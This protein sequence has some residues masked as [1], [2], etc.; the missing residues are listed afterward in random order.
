MTLQI[1]LY[2]LM[3][4]T[5]SERVNF[6]IT[7]Q[8]PDRAEIICFQGKVATSAFMDMNGEELTEDDLNELVEGTRNIFIKGQP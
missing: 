2:R 5:S 7:P 6:T 8:D 3:L 4:L 1:F